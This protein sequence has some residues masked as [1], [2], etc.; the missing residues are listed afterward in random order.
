MTH[1]RTYPPGF[2]F[3]YVSVSLTRLQAPYGLG[4]VFLT[5]LIPLSIVLFVDL[6]EY[7]GKIKVF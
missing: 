3:A 7:V 1:Y 4:V 6:L 2:V 5:L